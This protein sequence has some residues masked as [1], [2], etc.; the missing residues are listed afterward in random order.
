M[1]PESEIDCIVLASVL[2]P[3][4]VPHSRPNHGPLHQSPGPEEGDGDGVGGGGRPLADT[5]SV[6]GRSPNHI[7]E[8]RLVLQTAGCLQSHTWPG[9]EGTKHQQRNTGKER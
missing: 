2:C 3:Q 1:N 5:A 8:P 7:L 4:I 6:C 9:V